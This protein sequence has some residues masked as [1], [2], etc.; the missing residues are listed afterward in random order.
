[1]SFGS[2]M[3]GFFLVE[4][5]EALRQPE[6]LQA[7]LTMFAAIAAVGLFSLAIACARMAH[8]EENTASG[9]RA[10]T[11]ALGLFA[12]LWGGWFLRELGEEE[13]IM[14]AVLMAIG[15][16]FVPNLFFVTESEALGRRARAHVPR[17]RVLALLAVPFLPGGGRGALFLLLYAALIMV[18]SVLV[19]VSDTFNPTHKNVSD[20]LTVIAAALG[21]LWFY[22]AL[23]AGLGSFRKLDFKGRVV[24][25]IA[26]PL[27]VLLSF[28][29]PSLVGLFLD[30]KSWM[31]FEHPFF[32]F[33]TLEQLS[34]GRGS[35]VAFSLVVLGAGAVLAV[36]INLPR[37]VRG[38]FE[39]AEARADRVRR[40]APPPAPSTPSAAPDAVPES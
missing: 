15:V 30:V 11:L 4:E 31:E 21:Y 10:M 33:Y 26:I 36:A 40:E 35:R 6:T 38:L 14:F 17:N 25:R 27:A 37:L 2:F 34:R 9:L 19:V 39:V 5:P 23:P 7:F 22:L 3:F 18:S 24:L 28:F 32:P 13:G 29:L 16:G 8:A 20:E 1:V 12:V